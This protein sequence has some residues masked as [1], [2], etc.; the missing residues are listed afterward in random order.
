MKLAKVNIENIQKEKANL[1]KKTI[2]YGGR[3]VR[4]PG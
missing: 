4:G 2:E 1:S 3:N